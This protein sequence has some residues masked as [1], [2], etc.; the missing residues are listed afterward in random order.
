MENFIFKNPTQLIFGKGMISKITEEIPQDKKV[1]LTFGGGSVKRNGVYDQ[2]CKAL[3]KH[4]TIEFWGIESNPD[5]STLR[6]AIAL[7]KKENIDYLLA[8]GGGSVIDGTKLVAAGLCYEGDS[9]ELVLNPSLIKTAV[10]LA[11]VLTLPATGSEMNCGGVISCRENK[12]KYSFASPY[13]FPVFSV[14]DPETTYSL[15]SHQVACGLVDTFVHVMEQ[16]MTTINQSRIM[17]R[18][19]EGILQTIVEI[20]PSIMKDQTQYDLMAD[21]MLSATMGLNGFVSMGVTQD[22]ATHMIGHELTALHGLTHGHTLAIVFPGLLR[23]LKKQKSDKILQYGERIWNITNGSK[24]EKIEETIV[25]TETFFRSL[26]LTTRLSEES[27]GVDTI[28]EVEKRFN[29]RKVAYGEN[30]NVTGEVAKEIL[31]NTL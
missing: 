29:D 8:V 2:V 20:G 7:G 19:A 31:I 16:Y 18:W 23:V 6:K 10:P 5:I 28:N 25:K 21:F 12:L 3:E 4:T 1:M 13:T 17:D 22:W 15:P 11:S 24:E 14:L 27:I 9:W 26:G 30:E